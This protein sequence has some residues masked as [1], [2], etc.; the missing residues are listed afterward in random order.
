MTPTDHRGPPRRA[1][2]LTV[3]LLA[4][5]ALVPLAPPPLAAATRGAVAAGPS[6]PDLPASAPFRFAVYGDTRSNPGMHA[7]L[8][9][10]I[11]A[12]RPALVLHVGDLVPRGREPDD[13][14]PQFFAPAA[15]LLAQVPLFPVLG[16]HEYRGSGPL[17]YLDRF[18]LPG[19]G[20]WYAFTHGSARFV[21][22]DVSEG[23]EPFAPGSAQYAWLRDELASAAFAAARWHVVWFHAPPFTSAERDGALNAAV[24]ADL[25]PLFERAGVDVV[26]NGDEHAYR[27]SVRGGIHYVTTGG[28][29]A[30]LH[31]V[32]APGPGADLVLAEKTFEYCVV[33]VAPDR[34]AVAAF[35]PD[36]SVLERFA[37]GRPAGRPSGAPA[38]P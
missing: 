38:S 33:D 35:R 23:G 19:G 36:G 30:P 6:L 8:A 11:L 3:G 31:R 22:L 18:A 13:W 16:N 9:D 10:A 1:L 28:G 24:R 20:R 34:L 26:F 2:L 4:L 7:R 25:V 17:R 32:G 14:G 21:A 5:I 15:A 37:A 27:H 12:S 29:G